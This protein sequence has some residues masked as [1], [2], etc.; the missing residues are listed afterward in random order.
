VSDLEFLQAPRPKRVGWSWGTVVLICGVAAVTLVLALQ[1]ARRSEAQPRPGQMAPD[2]TLETFDGQMITLSELRGQLVMINFWGSWCPPCDQEAPH[3]QDLYEQYAD[4]G[5][6]VIGVNWLDTPSGASA[7]I[8]RHGLTFPNG[9]DIQERIAR[10]YRIQGAPENFLIG[11]DG[12]VIM[13]WIGP[14]TFPMVAEV[15]DRVLAE[16]GA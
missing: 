1:L 13:A 8:A 3:L 2:F 5:F 6:I 15:I 16:E 12:R 4:V 7:F 14:V 11:R 9:K 10:A